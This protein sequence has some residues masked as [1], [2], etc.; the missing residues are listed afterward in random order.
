ML[1]SMEKYTVNPILSN[2]SKLKEI[3]M[4]VLDTNNIKNYGFPKIKKVPPG[5]FVLKK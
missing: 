4:K 5:L 3:M 2:F 1:L